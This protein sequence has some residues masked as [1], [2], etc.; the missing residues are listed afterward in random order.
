MGTQTGT[1]KSRETHPTSPVSS[2]RC[3]GIIG[4]AG[5][6]AAD[7]KFLSAEAFEG[8]V[9]H[10]VTLITKWT[11]PPAGVSTVT[12]PVRI[13]SGGSA[14]ADHVAV[15]LFLR[16]PDKYALDLYLPCPWD[17]K[18]KSF[19]DN[20]KS[21]WQLNPGRTL[22]DYHRVFARDS[23][24]HTNASLD[25]IDE[26]RQKGAVLHAD[27][28]H[29]GFHARNTELALACTHLLAFT[30]GTGSPVEGGT[31]D[32]WTKARIP[33]RF[34]RHV[35]LSQLL[36]TPSLSVDFA[37]AT[38]A[39]TTFISTVDPENVSAPQQSTAAMQPIT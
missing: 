22:N 20:G 33:S 14:W 38:M 16:H 8:M 18:R 13:A 34:K 37:T 6:T 27:A 24:W 10:S 11:L 32:T 35:S 9:Q 23:G 36:Q 19:H 25:Q 30:R 7:R 39:P 3:V 17:A 15:A 21:N 12:I 26:A 31:R 2:N 4:T 28:K 29:Y 1:S 5:R